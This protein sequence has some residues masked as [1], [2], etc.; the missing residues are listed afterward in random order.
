MR[1]AFA[2][3]RLQMSGLSSYLYYITDRGPF[4]VA[5][6]GVSGDILKIFVMNLSVKRIYVM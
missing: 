3:G 5:H 4:S 2:Y 1:I 6:I